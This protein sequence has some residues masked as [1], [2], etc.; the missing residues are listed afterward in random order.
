MKSIDIF[1]L[2]SS[3]GRGGERLPRHPQ[4]A[5]AGIAGGAAGIFA[6]EV[7]EERN[8]TGDVEISAGLDARRVARR[9]R[10]VDDERAGGEETQRGHDVAV[11]PE[12]VHPR[13][14]HE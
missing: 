11:G 12:L 14:P 10:A 9:A 4:A 8:V 7:A 5:V 3:P 13:R 6:D 1:I 2:W